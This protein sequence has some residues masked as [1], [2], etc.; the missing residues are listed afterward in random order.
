MADKRF[1]RTASDR[2][3]K[4]LVIGAAVFALG[5]QKAQAQ[6]FLGKITDAIENVN[7][8]LNQKYLI[9]TT[10]FNNQL[11]RLRQNLKKAKNNTSQIMSLPAAQLI[12]KNKVKL[13]KQTKVSKTSS[14]EISQSVQASNLEYASSVRKKL[15]EKNTKTI[16]EENVKTNKKTATQ[17][18]EQKKTPKYSHDT[19]TVLNILNANSR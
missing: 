19:Q 7:H 3:R 10:S 5:A 2:L 11:S 15:N 6:G 13:E 12:V 16:S 14:Q 4:A 18:S 17:T 8:E 1:K 9:P